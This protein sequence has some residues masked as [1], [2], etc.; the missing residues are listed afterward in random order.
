[1]KRLGDQ[2]SKF[3][4]ELVH[5]EKDSM[6]QVS[7]WQAPSLSPHYSQTV[8]A[9]V[10]RRVL[11]VSGNGSRIDSMNWGKEIGQWDWIWFFD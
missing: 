1:M 6:G 10:L 9:G 4:C 11:F 8:L 3:I 5:I 2:V 7:I